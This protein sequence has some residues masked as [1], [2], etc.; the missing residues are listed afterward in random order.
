[1]I[2]ATT[3]VTTTAVTTTTTGGSGN[4]KGSGNGNGN[5]FAGRRSGKS[6][7]LNWSR[8]PHFSD[9]SGVGILP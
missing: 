3:T 9:Y 5:A 2:C 8:D 6:F 7:S 4:G 1:M